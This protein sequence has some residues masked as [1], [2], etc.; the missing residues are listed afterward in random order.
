MTTDISGARFSGTNYGIAMLGLGFSSVVFNWLSGLLVEATAGF[1]RKLY[2]R[3]RNLRA[4]DNTYARLSQNSEKKSP[5]KKT[6]VSTKETVFFVALYLF[7]FVRRRFWR[8]RTCGGK[9]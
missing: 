7:L 9:T 2:P 5:E 3:R 1:F 4:S 6:T 8:R